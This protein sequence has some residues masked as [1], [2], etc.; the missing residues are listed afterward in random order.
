MRRYAQHVVRRGDP[1]EGACDRLD[2]WRDR[3]EIARYTR[4]VS[5]R[6][7]ALLAR[8]VAADAVPAVDAAAL[9]A[10]GESTSV[11]MGRRTASMSG[12][13]KLYVARSTAGI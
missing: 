1:V 10:V 5:P 3:Q 9:R 13:L 2:F 7:S 8:P 4:P 6:D 12:V 11:M